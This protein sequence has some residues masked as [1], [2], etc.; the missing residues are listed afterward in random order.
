VP[1]D[2]FGLPLARRS[3]IV[4]SLEGEFDV[5][6]VVRVYELGGAMRDGPSYLNGA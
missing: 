5:F 4:E 1:P 3:F 6:I 2:G